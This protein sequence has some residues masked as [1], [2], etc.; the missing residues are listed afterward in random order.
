MAERPGAVGNVLKNPLILGL[1]VLFVLLV[2]AF[3][4]NFY[5]GEVASGR[6]ASQ[7]KFANNMKVASQQVGKD[8]ASI[9]GGR[10]EAFVSLASNRESFD[11]N[12]AGL[13]RTDTTSI[14]SA[15]SRVASTWDSAATQVDVILMSREASEYLRDQSSD[16]AISMSAIQQENNKIVATLLRLGAAANEIA[17][18][19]RQNLLIERMSRASDRMVD[20]SASENAATAFTR[21]SREF[22]RVLNGFMGGDRELLLNAATNSEVRTSLARVE[23]LFRSI[24]ARSNEIMARSEEVVQGKRAAQLLSI[25]SNTALE[26]VD[27]LTNALDNS[28]GA[29]GPGSPLLTVGAAALAFVFIFLI[30]MLIYREASR[31]VSESAV[32]NEMNQAAI[33]QL[34]DELADLADG[35][36]RVQATVTESFTGAIADSINFSIDQMRGLVSKINQTSSEVR[37]AAEDTKSSV[38]QLE[39]ASQQQ[40]DKITDVS[41]SVN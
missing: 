7:L 20:V 9:A 37:S 26:A 11:S 25:E 4:A 35:D 29:L 33:L 14:A 23:E 22:R 21:D 6:T 27:T 17:L 32:Q 1:I 38:S 39:E 24:T 12:L 3:I 15:V 31:S 16:L 28:G 30:S 18:A 13:R 40:A 10:V 34:L 19:Q 5:L 2:A 41:E 8:A 36:L